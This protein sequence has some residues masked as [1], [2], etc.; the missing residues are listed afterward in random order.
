M[1]GLGSDKNSSHKTR[2][3]LSSQ[4]SEKKNILQGG[5][6]SILHVFFWLL[7]ERDLKLLP[8]AEKIQIKSAEL[9]CGVGSPFEDIT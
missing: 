6:G 8:L 4:T 9:E 2:L 5:N 1:I 7:K 3:D